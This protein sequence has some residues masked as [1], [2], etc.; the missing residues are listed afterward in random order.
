MSP[1]V[2]RPRAAAGSA[3]DTPRGT[4]RPF[5]RG[6]LSDLALGARLT[7]S[8]GREGWTRTVLAAL[9]VG[10][11]VALLLAAASLP[12][13]ERAHHERSAARDYV[14][15]GGP[16]LSRGDDTMLI[17]QWD[18]TFR[19]QSIT[20]WLVQP[21]GPKAPVP[22]GLSADPAPDQLVVSPALARLLGS[23]SGA[24][25]RTRLNH[26]IVDTIARAGLS[27]PNELAF[28]LG[29]A[30]LER[31]LG[32][33]SGV[34]RIDHFGAQDTAEGLDPVLMLLVVIILVVLLMPVAVFIGSAT[35]FGGEQRDRRLAALRLVGADRRMAAR[36]AAGES[37]VSAG[38]GVVLGVLFL[39]LGRQFIVPRLTLWNISAFAS[40]VSPNPVLA[41]LI[42]LG[43]LAS[44]VAVSLFALRHVVIEPLGV[45]RRSGSARRRLWWRLALPLIGLALLVPAFNSVHREGSGPNK[46][47]FSFGIGLLLIGVVALLPWLI[48]LVVRHAGGSTV[49]WQLAV[50]RLQLNSG[51]PTRAA[52]GVAVAVAGGIAL[53]MTFGSAQSDYT[54][55]TG[56]D[57]SRA[58]VMS[59]LS[60][61]VDAATA[62]RSAARFHATPGVTSVDAVLSGNIG[63]AGSGATASE[64]AASDAEEPAGTLVVGDCATLARLYKV[65]PCSDGDVFLAAGPQHSMGDGPL[66]APGQRVTLVPP[67]GGPGPQWTV[68]SSARTIAAAP[69]PGGS[70]FVGVMA[71]PGAV[72]ASELRTPVLTLYLSTDHR[73]DGLEYLRNTAAAISP[74]MTVEPLAVTARNNQFSTIQ[75]GL[76]IGMVAVLL[77]IGASLLVGVL[78]QLREQR[79]TLAVLVAFGTRRSTLSA[80]VLWQTAIPMLLG[81]VLAAAVG[82]GLGSALLAVTGVSV[83]RLPWT[84][85]AEMS[86][87][88]V[89]VVLLVTAASLP[90]LWRLLRPEGLRSE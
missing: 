22:P 53:Q 55:A 50:R 19:D 31:A 47:Q 40:D 87:A 75:R 88:A 69:D 35:R 24:L 60:T 59:T 1:R 27:G 42:V 13:I 48:E 85:I 49:S 74:M 58:Q 41:A 39:L 30:Q 52:S 9:G 18:T 51:T 81:L 79:R 57:P 65:G 64:P 2:D 25:L 10:L 11:G 66:P 82:I 71:T 29:S 63:W 83:T 33:G 38:V 17:S 20:G 23:P 46:Y 54:K 5:L 67:G 70:S 6:W 34:S 62:D 8:G 36:V 90:A 77:L 84:G 76:S 44:A 16:Q 26:P 86:G 7:L 3:P 72:T 12:A 15:V 32:D 61:G 80:S 43:V 73:P 14:Y 28:Y 37:L 21:E 4:G 78:E 89:V 56:Q 68:P 45:V